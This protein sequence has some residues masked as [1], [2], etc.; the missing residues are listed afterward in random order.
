MGMVYFPPPAAPPCVVTRTTCRAFSPLRMA[1]IRSL[2][3]ITS[4]RAR[5]AKG[6]TTTSFIMRSPDVS[7][8]QR[9]DGPSGGTERS[10][11]EQ[12]AG[13]YACFGCR[14]VHEEIGRAHV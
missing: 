1:S 14:I 4:P 9:R 11:A 13:Q 2:S 8:E 10:S 3:V 6:F 7:A 5:P 12:H